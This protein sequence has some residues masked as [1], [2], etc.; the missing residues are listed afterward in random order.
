MAKRLTK[1]ERVGMTSELMRLDMIASPTTEQV[2]RREA[3]CDLLYPKSAGELA[4]LAWARS[5][6]PEQIA[7]CAT[8]SIDPEMIAATATEAGEGVYSFTVKLGA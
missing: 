2:A 6:T 4:D 1:R 3:L 7:A 8:R 5:R